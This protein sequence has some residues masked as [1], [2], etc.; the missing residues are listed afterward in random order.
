MTN[1]PLKPNSKDLNDLKTSCLSGEIK[2]NTIETWL[3]ESS[4]KVNAITFDNLIL[5]FR[6]YEIIPQSTYE[7]LLKTKLTKDNTILKAK[8]QSIKT[9]EERL[10]AEEKDLVNSFMEFLSNNK[11]YIKIDW[12]KE[13]FL[14]DDSN[15]TNNDEDDSKSKAEASII[16]NADDIVDETIDDVI[17]QIKTNIHNT[18]IKYWIPKLTKNKISA[19]KYMAYQKWC[20][21][22]AVFYLGTLVVA[23]GLIT[24]EELEIG[25]QA[26]IADKES[27]KKE[28]E[29]TRLICE[30][31]AEMNKICEIKK[32][33]N[34]L[35][36][37]DSMFVG[38]TPTTK[39][40]IGELSLSE[41]AL[42]DESNGRVKLRYV[43]TSRNAK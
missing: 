21:D 8:I 4:T 26:R 24:R 34:K 2:M 10:K 5:M 15:T 37:L 42:H 40:T 43:N 6:A 7:G 36:A 12:F 9:A 17:C 16:F 19:E 18:L 13:W 30:R 38:S 3:S 1:F 39:K 33:E 35:Q 31:E 25:H 11:E 22:D 32:Q 20:D 14:N 41:F 29:R 28:I 23:C 27:T